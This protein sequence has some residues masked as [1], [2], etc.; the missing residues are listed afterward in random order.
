M[1]D[2]SKSHSNKDSQFDPQPKQVRS[3][4]TLRTKRIGAFKGRE[5]ILDDLGIG[6]IFPG[7]QK[8]HFKWHDLVA[9][10]ASKLYL[11]PIKQVQVS[12]VL[13]HESGETLNLTTGSENFEYV[14]DHLTERYKIHPTWYSD[15]LSLNTSKPVVETLWES[16]SMVKERELV[17]LY[18]RWKSQPNHRNIEAIIKKDAE[19]NKE[20]PLSLLRESDRWRP[21]FEFITQWF[22]HVPNKSDGHGFH[23][24][25]ELEESIGVQMP[26]ALREW[27]WL[28]GKK[29][30]VFQD[31]PTLLSDQRSRFRSNS[32]QIYSENKQQCEWRVDDLEW[33]DPPVY[34][35]QQGKEKI[36][37]CKH[38]SRFV[39]LKLFVET[40]E[41]IIYESVC[42]QDS[43]IKLFGPLRT[44]YRGAEARGESL[45]HAIERN[46]KHIYTGLWWPGQ[47]SIYGDDRTLIMTWKNKLVRVA[48]GTQYAW[49]RFDSIVQDSGGWYDS[50]WRTLNKKVREFK[51]LTEN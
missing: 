27:Y 3:E 26:G 35:Y 32:L 6:Q 4:H 16:P 28:T 36:L 38:L 15:L 50:E 31:L 37:Q 10:E 19:S 33:E 24:T 30:G 43:P 13:V 25:R 48:A 18:D 5:L 34:L 46:Y 17:A 11:E 2:R 7:G 8:L 41:S 51:G 22:D 47:C 39:F 20:T 12:L 21:M 9:I 40:L 45:V 44:G 29:L 49:T 14:V 1:S 23:E 42:L